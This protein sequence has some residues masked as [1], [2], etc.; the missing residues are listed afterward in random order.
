MA[1][2]SSSTSA[3]DNNNITNNNDNHTTSTSNTDDAPH[4]NNCNWQ[5]L[6]HMF[7]GDRCPE[8][9]IAAFKGR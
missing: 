5:W 3:V 7:A 4:R 9:I 8:Y 6:H 2:S 1:S